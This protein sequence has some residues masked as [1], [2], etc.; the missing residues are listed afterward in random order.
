M[1]PDTNSLVTSSPVIFLLSSAKRRN[2]YFTNLASFQ[3]ISFNF[4]TPTP[5]SNDDGAIGHDAISLKTFSFKRACIVMQPK[6]LW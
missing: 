3:Q 2:G 1:K 6:A 4:K 5:L